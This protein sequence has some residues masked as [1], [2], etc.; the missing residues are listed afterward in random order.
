MT[1]LVSAWQGSWRVPASGSWQPGRWVSE[2]QG[3]QVGAVYQLVQEDWSILTMGLAIVLSND[4]DWLS[5]SS[6]LR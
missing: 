1:S 2:H 5:I 3:V 6:T 4:V